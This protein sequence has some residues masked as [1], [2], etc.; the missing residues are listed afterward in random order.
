VCDPNSHRGLR[1]KGIGGSY[2][3][4]P[5]QRPLRQR[6]THVHVAP[7]VAKVLTRTAMLTA[8]PS[9]VISAYAT[10]GTRRLLRRSCSVIELQVVQASVDPS[11]TP[12]NQV[13][14]WGGV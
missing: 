12:G 4:D 9:S 1:L 10:N 11:P 2:N 3:F 6:S 14:G 7:V 5:D 13:P 8:E